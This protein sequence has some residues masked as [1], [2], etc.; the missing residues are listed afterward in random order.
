[1]IGEISLLQGSFALQERVSQS[2][3]AG[4][5]SRKEPL[6]FLRRPR[7]RKLVS[8]ACLI[9]MAIVAASL[10][11]IYVGGDRWWP[12]TLLLFAPRWP[13]AI[14][15]AVLGP[16]AALI[17]PRMLIAVLATALLVFGPLMG[18]RLPRIAASPAP[19]INPLRVLTCNTHNQA[20]NAQRLREVIA[21]EKPDI[22]TLQ[23][24]AP[25]N[26]PSVFGS[27][28]NVVGDGEYLLASRFPIHQIQRL[29]IE[30]RPT[31]G[32]RYEVQT[33]AGPVDFI[34]VHLASPHYWLRDVV[35][36]A[37][38]GIVRLKANIGL[39]SEEAAAIRRFAESAHRPFLIAGDFNLPPD[40]A[41]FRRD[42]SQVTDAFDAAGAGYGWTYRSKW[43][44]T[45]ID[46]ILA[47]AG[48]RCD[49]VRIGPD[50]GSPHRPLIADLEREAVEQPRPF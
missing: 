48:W 26:E 23:E 8:A 28:W 44:M 33:P 32:V 2:A 43:T 4:L 14:P 41:I 11:L 46:H 22:V 47:G 10:L 45:R 50:V 27:G 30:N 21:A 24:W 7:G 31:Y 49:H 37:R 35:R 3:P 1:M 15:L 34:G 25:A 5:D 38:W 36:F 39:R 18:L 6:T 19:G 40:S 20:L 29:K 9:Y 16:A 12:A 13:F 17:R 42:L